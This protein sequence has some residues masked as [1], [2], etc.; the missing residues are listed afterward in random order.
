MGW[1]DLVAIAI[2]VLPLFDGAQRG[3]FSRR[4]ALKLH[5]FKDGGPHGPS[6]A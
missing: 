3:G 1:Q 5:R 6:A 4:A 2:V